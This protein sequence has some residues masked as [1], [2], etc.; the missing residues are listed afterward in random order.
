LEL[1]AQSRRSEETRRFLLALTSGYGGLPP[2]EMRA[3]DPVVYVGD[4]LAFCFRAFSVEADVARSLLNFDPELKEE[5]EDEQKEEEKTILAEEDT[6]YLAE[7]PMT[8]LEMLHQSMGGLVRPLKSRVLQVIS[9]LARRPDDDEVESDDGMNDLEEEGASTRAQLSQLYEICGLLLFYASALDKAV[10][11]ASTTGGAADTA[12]TLAEKNPLVACILDCLGEATNAYEASLRV[13]GAMLEQLQMVTG[14]TEAWLA[15]TMV[16]SI[17]D[18]RKASPGFS[19]DVECPASSQRTLSL[20]WTCDVLV[21]AALPSCKT[22]DDTVTL[23]QSI[24]IARQANL[25]DDVMQSLEEKVREKERSLI[26]VLVEKETT[27]VLDLCGLGTLVTAWERFKGVQ[28]EG[29]TMA[30]YPGLTQDEADSCM[31]EFYSSLYSPPIPSFEN[32]IKD[33]TLRKLARAK[34]AD[35]VC[36]IYAALYDAMSQQDG[37]YDDLSFLGHTPQQVVTL[38]S[39]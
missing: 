30:S 38:F 16:A 8:A 19:T 32:A 34:I 5:D 15:H 18:V 33:P 37:G 25:T 10:Q 4:M 2:I 24:A 3:H 12:S 29:M 31:K 11:K 28:V 17:V 14:D 26:D 21:E 39:A 6:E 22:L 23:K 35:R 36:Q 20:D 27:D 13:Y 1:I 9:S 7:R